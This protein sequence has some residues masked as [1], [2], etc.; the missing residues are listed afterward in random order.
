MTRRQPGKGADRWI[1]WLIGVVALA[2]V[3]ALGWCADGP[4]LFASTPS[5]RRVHGTWVFD[6][7]RFDESA[8]GQ[9]EAVRDMPLLKAMIAGLRRDYAKAELRLD[10]ATC[11]VAGAPQAF[12][13]APCSYVGVSEQ[14]L[15]VDLHDPA[16][17]PMQLVVDPQDP[18][19]LIWNI[20]GSQIPLRRGAAR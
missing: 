12:T 7:A 4:G 2:V 18:D 15:M 17:P 13:D 19:R 6:G 14:V 3:L 16:K 1:L 20:M 11:S 10:P 9:E 8:R 5:P